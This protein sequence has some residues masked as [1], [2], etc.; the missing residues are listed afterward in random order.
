MKK[1][2]TMI[3]LLTAMAVSA[4]EWKKEVHSADE[5]TGI[6]EVVEYSYSCNEFSM[7]VVEGTNGWAIY[8][9][10]FKPDHT[11]VNSSNNFETYATIG[12]YDT[13]GKLVEGH[14][15]CKLEL[16]NMYRMALMAANKRKNKG[17]YAVNEYLKNGKGYVRIIIP[18]IQG[19][20]F[21]VKIPCMNE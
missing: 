1:I 2:I 8:G 20:D 9:P 10:S 3:M 5:L 12:F 14:R 6:P 11:H 16:T 4:Q 21:D 17:Q 18:T 13:D 15:N 7:M 19:P